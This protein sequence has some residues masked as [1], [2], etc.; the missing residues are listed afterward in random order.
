MTSRSGTRD[1]ILAI[2][3]RHLMR[4]GYHAFSF[5]DIAS[6]IGVKTAAVHYHFPTKPDLV[7]TVIQAYARRFEAWSASVAAAPAADRLCGYFE[8]GRLVAADGRVCPLSMITAQQ[9]AV[10]AE[11]V[12]EVKR[13]QA[14]IL[15]FYASSLEEARVAGQ[16]QFLGRAED[17]A[18][19]V[20][21][22]LVGA[23]LLARVF[24]PDAYLKVMRQQART[25]GLPER[26][27]AFVG[28]GSAAA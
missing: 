20:A 5:A 14:P 26:W 9:D 18:L 3:D 27:P 8:I 2:A 4:H 12:A 15:A 28:A 7:I 1:R 10:P 11:V 21:C 17:E 13:L 25:L 16:V 24:G 22:A 19:L 6:E 23:Q